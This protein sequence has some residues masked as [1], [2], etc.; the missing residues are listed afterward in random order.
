MSNPQQTLMQFLGVKPAAFP[1]N[2]RYHDVET[3]V[4]VSE[5]RSAASGQLEQ[6]TI[7]YLRRRFLPDPEKFVVVQEHTVTQGE[8]LDHV[9]A[10]Y[11]GDPEQFWRI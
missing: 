5:R 11:I 4:V 8:R 9:A 6:K 10:K 3:A 1:A 7:V 2:S